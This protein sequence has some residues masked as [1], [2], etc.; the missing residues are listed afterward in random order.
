MPRADL[1]VGQNVWVYATAFDTATDKW[2]EE[3]FGNKAK[4]T[5]LLG[6]I[7]S[8]FN[9]NFYSIYF[10][11]DATS[12]EIHKK[13]AHPLTDSY[14][15]YNQYF[16]RKLTPRER[17]DNPSSSESSSEDSGDSSSD[18]DNEDEQLNDDLNAPNWIFEKVEDDPRP[19]QYQYAKP[20]L[21][22][23]ILGHND[24]QVEASLVWQLFTRFCPLQWL[25]N[26]TVVL[27][28]EK[29]QADP[30]W[31]NPLDL[32]E[33]LIFLGIVCYMLVYPARRN[34]WNI[35]VNGVHGSIFPNANFGRF[36]ARSRFE[37]I[38]K[39]LTLGDNG[40]EQD[41]LRY[42]RGWIDAVRGKFRTAIRPG[43]EL[44]LDETMIENQNHDNADCLTY[45]P[46]KPC[47]HGHQFWTVVDSESCIL[48]NYELNEGKNITRQRPFF[49]EFGA[50]TATTLRLMEPY[51]ETWRV[52]YI[53]SWFQSVKTAIQL[54]LRGIL[55]IG[56]VKTA[57]RG[58]PRDELERRCPPQ[59]GGLSAAHARIRA[60]GNE[61]TLMA[62][63][64]RSSSKHKVTFL[65]TTSSHRKADQ[66]YT[67]TKSGRAVEQTVMGQRW[68]SSFGK[69]DSFNHAMVGSGD[70]GWEHA[71][72]VQNKRNFPLF[73]GTLSMIDTNVFNAMKY[74]FADDF[75]D[76]SHVELRSMLAYVLIN[77]PRI[78]EEDAPI[79]DPTYAHTIAKSGKRRRCII[80]KERYNRRSEVK[81]YCTKCGSARHICP[82]SENRTCFSDHIRFGLPNPTR[83]RKAPSDSSSSDS[84]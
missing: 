17:L 67:F 25:E 72:R 15:I 59:S 70:N 78:G 16:V 40:D 56:I 76:I 55:S 1:A 46:R 7:D 54:F 60:E 48:V 82:D 20:V 62:A 31:T 38:L 14:T 75:G 61:F 12:M 22:N 36:M 29:A 37:L 24:F 80:C 30:S 53:D 33:L 27:T 26:E 49:A 71:L 52:V 45:I 50:C 19:R 9:A 43:R 3:H 6:R 57:H 41:K 65:A 5:K 74:F 23:A 64:W 21:T 69:V 58:Y 10:H 77:N 83:K 4:E 8:I 35:G 68:Y 13:H 39:H 2:S 66:D 47:P 81:T 44:V 28:N 42:F 18:S 32:G 34:H 84:D 63:Q 11:Y 79:P 51:F 73:T